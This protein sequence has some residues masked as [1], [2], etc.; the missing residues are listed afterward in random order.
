MKIIEKIDIFL[1]EA[2]VTL[3]QQLTQ[4]ALKNSSSIEGTKI[5]PKDAK[6][7]M[8]YIDR[9]PKDLKAIFNQAKLPKALE[10]FNKIK[11]GVPIF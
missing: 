3:S 11:K 8:D 2:R 5:S 7:L 10:I 6:E 1:D 9:L 4:V